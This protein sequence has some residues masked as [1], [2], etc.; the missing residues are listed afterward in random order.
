MTKGKTRYRLC[1]FAL[2]SLLLAPFQ[3]WS[4]NNHE[5]GSH[6]ASIHVQGIKITKRTSIIAWSGLSTG[7][8]INLQDLDKS[9]QALFDTGLFKNVGIKHDG[10][11]KSEVQVTLIVE[12]KRYHLIYPRLSRNGDGDVGVGLRYRGSNLFGE[13]QSISLAYTEKDYANGEDEKAIKLNYRIPLVSAPYLMRWSI[14][15][16]ETLVSTSSQTIAEQSDR[17]SFEVG[18]DWV[19]L[20][21]DI[22]VTV[23]LTTSL[24]EKRLDETDPELDTTPGSFNSLGLA[25]EYD[26]IHEE[27]YRRF[28]RFFSLSLSKGQR[29]LDSD[30]S[31][32]RLKAEAIFMTRMNATDNLNSRMQV[33]LA[34]DKVFNEYAYDIG[35]YNSIRGVEAES[36]SG[37]SRWIANIEYIKGYLRWPSFRTAFFTDIGNVF[38][39]AKTLNGKG[40]KTSIGLGLRWKL[41][42][43][44]KTDLV[45][46]FA[47][48]PQ[49]DY[50]RV[51]GSTSLMF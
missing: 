4:S 48:N 2:L 19:S 8:Q 30:Y 21:F 41:A 5:C 46:D 14:E 32:T 36:A 3:A 11:C 31:A 37:N 33:S 34:S 9:R 27:K 1:A 24:S 45:I 39:Q 35:S 51:Y 6:I 20:P 16:K 15:R 38:E 29:L 13:D 49:D 44:V 26:A 7:Q 25:L 43:F 12:E 17:V 28:G 47:Y 18:R 22:P 50:S 42:S 23:L 10:L 40:W